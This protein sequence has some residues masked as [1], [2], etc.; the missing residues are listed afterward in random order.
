ML[1]HGADLGA[2]VGYRLGGITPD[3]SASV[4][5]QEAQVDY[6][7][8][9]DSVDS[10]QV[11]FLGAGVTAQRLEYRPGERVTA[12]DG[13][14][15]RDAMYGIDRRTGER[16]RVRT[17]RN[18]Q[19]RIAAD[20]YFAVIKEACE[21]AAVNPEE[22]WPRR[23]L[24]SQLRAVG[25]AAG[26]PNG[27][28]VIRSAEAL[29]R[30][31]E[32][33]WE[34]YWIWEG[35]GMDVEPPPVQ[36]DRAEVM[37]RLGGHHRALEAS[38]QLQEFDGK[39][40]DFSLSDADLGGWIWVRVVEQSERMNV[41]GNAGYEMTLTC[42][43]S[44]SMAA[45][46]ADPATREQWLETVRDASRQATDELMARVA[47]GRTGHEG[48]GQKAMPIRGLGYA[49]TVSIES[50]SRELD[51]HLHGHVMVPNR[52]VCVDG[53]ERTMATGGA[54]LVNH[55][56]WFQAQFERYLRLLSTDRGLVTGWEFD[57]DGRQWEVAGADADVM[58]F[59]SQAQ[60]LVRAETLE[61]LRE[62]SVGVTRSRL[63]VLDSRAK[64]KVTRA[65]GEQALT[66]GQVRARMNERAEE[67]GIEIGTA[68]AA[69]PPDSATQ[70]GAWDEDMWARTVE[71]VVCEN[72]GAEITARI[73]AAVRAF[74][75]HEWSE[76]Q[77]Q[78][79]VH[80]VLER[81]FTT[82][83][84]TAR[85]RVGVR[86]HASNRVADAERRACETFAAGFERNTHAIDPDVALSGL[87][88]WREGSGWIQRGRSF[89]PGQLALFTQMTIGRDRVSTVIGAA[90]SGKTTAIDAARTVLAAQ[91]QRVYGVCVAAIAAQ[92]LRD[93]ARVQAGTVTWLTMRI[94][95][96]RDPQDPIRLEAD[97]L[98][99]S[100]RPGDRAQAARI[101]T[102][103]TLPEMDHLVIDEASMIPATDM[104][105]VLG[106]AEEND[107]TVTLVGDHRQLQPVGPSGLFRQFHDSR[108]GA[109]LVENLRQRTDVGRECAA[110]LRDGDPEQALHKLAGA[111]QLVVVASQTEAE[112]VL[113]NAWAERA[114]RCP[115]PLDR[116]HA[117]GLESDRNDQVD[118]LNCLARSEAKSRGW[119]T[120]DGVTF[121][122]RGRTREIAIGDQIVITKNI[123]RGQDRS[124]AN[125]TRAVVT[126]VD[127]IG[128]DI[129]YRDGDRVCTSHLTALQVMRNVRHGYAMTTHKLQGQTVDSL[130]ID[131]G[132]D[133]DMSSAYVAFTR[134]RNDVLAVVN[135]A[136]IADGEQAAALLAAGPDARR[137]A[138]ISMTAE[139]MSQRGFTEQPTAHAALRRPLPL[140]PRPDQ[141][142]GMA[143]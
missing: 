71:E 137:D 64:R 57:L 56:W 37:R 84:V 7:L 33:A 41:V 88:Q 136:D 15:V 131:I 124:L 39:P 20:P 2:Q 54:D 34:M 94:N 55:S 102:R 52:V 4:A 22:L 28:V 83:E 112:R 95:F 68:F 48:D 113:I 86:K 79:K 78:A 115:E 143:G 103:F 44:F 73:E 40:L 109:E 126:A 45:F 72:K 26:R 60:A 139:R 47:H 91:G 104:A 129:A 46:V 30:S 123:T 87:D 21:A 49:A 14:I 59:Y 6:R 31:N 80:E 9:Q 18:R 116:L 117:T 107:I 120:G 62:E 101:R 82:G 8:G 23:D 16:I 89:T 58:A 27:T 111:G 13:R 97:R 133:R 93:T 24:S 5:V 130:V 121:R 122:D 110:F 19:A 141:G 43:K 25:R 75:P 36:F 35:R 29:L 53:V 74:A 67:F 98:A 65:K 99:A 114:A 108:P 76:E 17:E 92:A 10:R 51:P 96:A 77:V 142:L 118:I 70:P 138:V 106:W 100:R 12:A 69:A 63:Q 66:W 119:I 127:D 3:K 85:G 140:S 132:P 81:E 105:T 90:G 11:W 42:P 50:Y 61:S 135:I 38:G 1:A 134:H 128:V 32:H 125:G